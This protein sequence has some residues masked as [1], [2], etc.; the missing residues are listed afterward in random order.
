M[1]AVQAEDVDVPVSRWRGG[2]TSI[3]E[4]GGCWRRSLDGERPVGIVSIYLSTSD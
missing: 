3:N 4:H 1:V 2:I